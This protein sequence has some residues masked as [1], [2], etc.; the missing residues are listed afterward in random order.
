ML[1]HRP[2]SLLFLVCFVLSENAYVSTVRM[3]KSVRSPVVS[4]CKQHISC[5]HSRPRPCSP[6]ARRSRREEVLRAVLARLAGLLRLMAQTRHDTSYGLP[7]GPR[8]ASTR[9]VTRLRSNT[10]ETHRVPYASAMSARAMRWP[11]GITRPE[12]ERGAGKCCRPA[13]SCGTQ[14]VRL[15][16]GSHPGRRC[17]S[18]G[19]QCRCII[20][21]DIGNQRTQRQH[22]GEGR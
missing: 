10:P 8:T 17:S 15:W 22:F 21:E 11:S 7:C 19:S 6:L 18:A 20:G 1:E 14:C 5:L 4:S 13:H 12:L 3:W 9:R 16:K 2:Y